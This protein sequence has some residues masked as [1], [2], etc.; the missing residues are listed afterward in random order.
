MVLSDKGQIVIVKLM[1]AI[2]LF[3]AAILLYPAVSQSIGFAGNTSANLNC[4]APTN[5]S[6]T[7]ATCVVLD[8][9]L[10]YFLSICIAVGLAFVTGRKTITG[11]LAAIFTTIIVLM[12]ITPL[13]DLINLARGPGYLTCGTAALSVGR[14]MLCIFVD[15]WLFYFVV[16]TIAAAITYISLKEFVPEGPP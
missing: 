4:S 10:F 1:M 16:A 12:L 6:V 5:G 9:G 3:I 8:M 13:K 2:L 11:V 15:L 14:Q 7:T